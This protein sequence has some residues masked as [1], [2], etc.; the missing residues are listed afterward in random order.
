M[1]Y[2]NSWW[3][4]PKYYSNMKYEEAVAVINKQ[5]A[6]RDKRESSYVIKYILKNQ[7]NDFWKVEFDQVTWKTSSPEF[8]EIDKDETNSFQLSYLS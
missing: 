1:T 5:A 7:G 3:R 2:Q 4:N 8:E 6:L